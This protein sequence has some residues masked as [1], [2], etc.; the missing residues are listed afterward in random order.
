MKCGN[1]GSLYILGERFQPVLTL[2]VFDRGFPEPLQFPLWYRHVG[3]DLSCPWSSLFQ[4]PSQLPSQ[5]R[6]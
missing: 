5:R 6:G 4:N 3:A 1:D 2:E